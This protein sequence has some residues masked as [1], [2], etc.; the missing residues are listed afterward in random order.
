MQRVSTLRRGCVILTSRLDRWP[1]GFVDLQLDLL[2]QS[3]AVDYLLEATTGNRVDLDEEQGPGTDRRMATAICARLGCLTLGLVQ[4]AGTINTLRYSLHDYLLEWE[5]S[6]E[7]LLR[8]PDFDSTTLGY[9][10]SVAETWLTSY[11][12][13]PLESQWV[14]D[15]LCWF[16]PEPIPER[17][18]TNPWPEEILQLLPDDVGH[19]IRQKARRLMT[20]LYDFSLADKPSGSQRQF[21]LHQLVQ[22]VG[23]LWQRREPK[24]IDPHILAWKAME[25]DFVR[26]RTLENL[27]LNILPE[28]RAMQPHVLHA[29]DDATLRAEQPL[30][31]SSLFRSLAELCDAVGDYAAGSERAAWAIKLAASGQQNGSVEARRVLADAY[32]VA[33]G[34]I[35]CRGMLD[36]ALWAGRAGLTIYQSINEVEPGNLVYACDLGIA[37][38]NVGRVLEKKGDQEGALALFRKSQEIRKDLCRREPDNLAYKRELGIALANLGRV[39]QNRGDQDEALTHF[40]VSQEIS[41][42]LCHREP[43]SL[44]H[45]RDL[46]IALENVGRVLENK[47][48]LDGALTHFKKSQKIRE[49]LCRHEPD[50]LAHTRELG[51]A[52]ENIGRVLENKGD[53]DGALALFRKSQEI[54][55]GLC[56]RESDNQAYTREL[57]IALENIG[58]V[59]ENKG[60]Q[61]GALVLFKNSQEISEDLCRREPD[62]LAYKRELGIALTNL[63]RAREKSGDQERALAF[64]MKSQ[65]ISED[66][67]RREPDNLAYKRELG[68]ALTNVGRVLQKKGDQD[69]ALVFFKASQEIRDDLCRHESGNLIWRREKAYS[70]IYCGALL[71]RTGVRAEGLAQLHQACDLLSGLLD[72]GAG[73][74]S[75]AGDL[76]N[77]K[78]MLARFAESD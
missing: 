21:R 13:L 69:R 52:L 76:R 55:E 49:D 64:Y 68:V 22:E 72:S 44:A 24:Y 31:A 2:E 58:R 70:C 56:H 30:L 28:L 73:F 12:Q 25:R 63:G 3:A 48:D 51:I 57:G 47:G 59:L 53:Q 14:F 36:S 74:D 8:D 66:L 11:R 54:R 18:V 78:K 77:L 35:Q 16:S 42:D 1:Q 4:A 46:G 10:R 19:A 34:I 6:R 27:P 67:C 41:E 71:C 39:L 5:S 32:S 43:D 9:P 23:R 40:R 7:M 50:N 45:T 60:D 65:E 29:L 26:P 15:I 75:L 33:C 38:E 17:I 20:P 62:N 37:L 61:D